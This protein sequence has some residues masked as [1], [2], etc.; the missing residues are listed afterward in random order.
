MKNMVCAKV[1]AWYAAMIATLVGCMTSV[2]SCRAIIEC[3][4]DGCRVV[5]KATMLAACM[6]VGFLSVASAFGAMRNGKG[7]LPY[8]IAIFLSGMGALLVKFL[9]VV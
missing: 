1:S 9:Y 7:A 6:A 4:A 8:C 3:A 5:L 2:L